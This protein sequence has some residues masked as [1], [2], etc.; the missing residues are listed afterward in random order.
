MALHRPGNRLPPHHRPGEEHRGRRVRLPRIE[1]HRGVRAAE[2]GPVGDRAG[3]EVADLVQLQL[4]DRVFRVDDHR[5]A[6]QRQDVLLRRGVGREAVGGAEGRQLLGARGPGG[7]GDV[8]PPLV[9][10]VEELAAGGGDGDADGLAVGAPR[11]L[12]ALVRRLA[13]RPALRV[14]FG[15]REIRVHEVGHHALAHR[16]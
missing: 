11:F 3:V 13:G 9:Q 8:R 2:R 7:H 6:V 4:P 14:Q 1:P 12:D 10:P 5:Q 16:G 15:A